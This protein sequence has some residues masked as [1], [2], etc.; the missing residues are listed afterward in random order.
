MWTGLLLLCTYFY[1]T[2][3]DSLKCGDKRLNG[4]LDNFPPPNS[5]SKDTTIRAFPNLSGCK[6]VTV[7]IEKGN[8]SY[9]ITCSPDCPNC[10]QPSLLEGFAYLFVLQP[11][12]A[13][14]KISPNYSTFT[15]RDPVDPAFLEKCTM[16]ESNENEALKSFSRTSVLFV[17]ISFIILM[18][19]SLAWL[20]FYYVQRFR[21]AH[22]KDR[23]QRRLFNAA[24]KAL[25]RIP[26]RT[27]KAGDVELDTDC[28]VCIDP[29]AA[30]DIVRTLPCRHVFHKTCIDPWLL[31]HRTC[32]MCKGDILKAFGY[33]V[34]C[35]SEGSRGEDREAANRGDSP[36]PPSAASDSAVF[37]Y[38]PHL[39]HSDPFH[40]TPNSSPQLVLNNSNA[41]SFVVPLSVHSKAIAT[42][43]REVVLE[44]APERNT[45]SE[46]RSCSAGEP[47]PSGRATRSATQGQLVNLVQVRSRSMSVARAATFR[48]RM[49]TM[50]DEAN[51]DP[52]STEPK[53]RS[54]ST[55]SI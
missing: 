54:D 39:D 16:V 38:P 52:N 21:Y 18:V 48:G 27:L 8:F 9:I 50:K 4:T 43:P 49:E 14:L 20:V 17:S 32:P 25:A 24:K 6:P 53:Q 1:Y 35:S 51:F 40:F 46:G 3:Q 22:A 34:N 19:I 45:R 47:G 36:E 23:L 10:S 29:Y 42:P 41:K 11:S 30:G 12:E 55:E 44:A 7:P 37:A 15:L 28:P 26:T 31:E 13:G 33:Q 5:N 2:L